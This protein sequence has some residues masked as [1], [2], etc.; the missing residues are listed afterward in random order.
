M[1]TM[2]SPQ[3]YRQSAVL[4]APPEQLVVML[5]DGALRFLQQG[6]IA[7][8]N[9]QIE[10]SHRKLR[11]AEDIL[12]HLRQTLDMEQG[13]IAARLLAIYSFCERHLLLAR[14]DRDPTKIEQISELLRQLREAWVAIAES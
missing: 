4:T 3:A 13:E 5:Y 2:T 7:M 10:L 1:T 12:M 6:A 8:T 14:S 9:G 11:R